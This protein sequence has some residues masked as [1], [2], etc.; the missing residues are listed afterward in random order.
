VPEPCGALERRERQPNRFTRA[1]SDL[2]LAWNEE[3]GTP[4]APWSVISRGGAL[5]PSYLW[6]F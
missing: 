3:R 5:K 4:G 1:G 6:Q 2:I